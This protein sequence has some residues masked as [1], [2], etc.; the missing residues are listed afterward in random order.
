MFE[1]ALISA[2]L[3]TAG[4]YGETASDA[5]TLLEK[6]KGTGFT[7]MSRDDAESMLSQAVDMWTKLDSHDPEFGQALVLLGVLRNAKQ[8]GTVVE[9]LYQQAVDIYD[10]SSAA[11]DPGDIALA[12][13]LDAEALGQI[14]SADKSMPLKRRAIGIRTKHIA[15]LLSQAPEPPAGQVLTAFTVMMATRPDDAASRFVTEFREGKRKDFSTDLTP[16]VLSSAE[17]TFDELSR[18]IKQQGTVYFSLVIGMDGRPYQ[19]RLV[20]SAGFGLDERCLL[21]LENW[22]FAPAK[23]ATGQAVNTRATVQFNLH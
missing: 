3:L 15:E 2:L 7:P 1:R 11:L 13:E 5:H 10:H 21:A 8:R 6:A 14:G 16:T 19:I 17:P 23:D 9:P 18:L 22:R 4:A 20:R 12:L